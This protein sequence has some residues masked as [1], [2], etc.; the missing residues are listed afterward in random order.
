[1][2]DWFQMSHELQTDCTRSQGLSP[3]GE[4]WRIK[5][6]FWRCQTEEELSSR[7]KPPN[8]G[9]CLRQTFPLLLG[10]R[11]VSLWNDSPSSS[12]EVPQQQSCFSHSQSCPSD[13]HTIPLR[14]IV[15]IDASLTHSENRLA[16]AHE[17][18]VSEW[19]HKSRGRVSPHDDVNCS[20]AG[21]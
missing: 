16:S 18:A 15:N 2:R 3:D 13:T 19:C 5:L 12:S 9:V 4:Q 6:S 14:R 21:R 8:T 11:G 7:H 20:L 10:S 17:L 1:M